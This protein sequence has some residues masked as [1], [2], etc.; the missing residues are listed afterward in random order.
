M[1]PTA[2]FRLLQIPR[3]SWILPDLSVPVPFSN[4]YTY[5]QSNLPISMAI[6]YIFKLW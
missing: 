1:L 6:M 2:E 5:S 3:E 4:L